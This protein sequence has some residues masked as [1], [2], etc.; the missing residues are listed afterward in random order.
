MHLLVRQ[1]P[2]QFVYPRQTDNSVRQGKATPKFRG[3]RY[4]QESTGY[5]ITSRSESAA[6]A[7]GDQVPSCGA[8]ADGFA[9]P[10]ADRFLTIIHFAKQCSR[11]K[12]PRTTSALTVKS[13]AQ[14][15]HSSRFRISWMPRTDL[16]NLR[17]HGRR[18]AAFNALLWV[19]LAWKQRR[20]RYGEFA[21]VLNNL[22]LVFRITRVVY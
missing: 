14:R 13:V 12:S 4:S 22:R 10:F 9:T 6:A 18:F 16:L 21:S 8:G 20:T 11:R 19:P 7:S 3:Q 1:Q 2:L 15:K 17:R 5:R